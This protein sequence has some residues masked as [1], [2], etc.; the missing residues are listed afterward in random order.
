MIVIGVDPG[1]TGAIVGLNQDGSVY[2]CMDHKDL[3]TRKLC[4]LI[5][6]YPTDECVKIAVVERQQYMSK[7]GREQGAK[8]AFSLGKGYGFWVGFFDALG[9]EVLSPRPQEWQHYFFGPGTV[10][11]DP[12][13][14]SVREARRRLPDLELIPPRCRVPSH[15]RADAALIALYGLGLVKRVVKP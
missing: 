2:F 10:I 15:G 9:I 8:S 12:K 11:S 7:G 4:D 6:V 13:E 1:A 3:D 14:R 5:T